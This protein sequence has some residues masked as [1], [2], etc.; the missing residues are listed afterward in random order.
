MNIRC[1]I[2]LHDWEKDY[3]IGAS[4]RECRRCHRYEVFPISLGFWIHKKDG[5]LKIA[6]LLDKA[7]KLQGTIRNSSIEQLDE[8]DREHNKI[9]EEVEQEVFRLSTKKQ[10]GGEN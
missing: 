7:F 5:N 3:I 4:I 1:C 8:I 9:M 10:N 2:G 6:R